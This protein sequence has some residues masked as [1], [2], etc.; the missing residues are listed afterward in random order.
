[1]C[2]SMKVEMARR[3]HYV[4]LV[5]ALSI[6]VALGL[7]F[8][9]ARPVLR[10][11]STTSSPLIRS[12]AA[13]TT[14]VAAAV[15]AVDDLDDVGDVEKERND[16]IQAIRSCSKMVAVSASLDLVLGKP[17]I[18]MNWKS[19]EVIL[20]ALTALWKFSFAFN[21]ASASQMYIAFNKESDAYKAALDLEKILTTMTFV[22]RQSGVMVAIITATKVAVA[23]KDTL[24]CIN[25]GIMA[26]AFV[27]FAATFCAAMNDTKSLDTR[28][29]PNPKQASIGKIGRVTGRAMLLCSTAFF[30]E[31]AFALLLAASSFRNSWTSSI[32]ALLN[33]PNP[34]AIAGLLRHL[35]R[36][37]ISA[38]QD[39]VEVG[40]DEF[41]TTP[42]V[43]KA[44]HQSQQRF[45]GKV[46]GVVQVSLLT[47][48]LVAVS[49]LPAVARFMSTLAGR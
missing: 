22:W 44:L 8:P 46:K 17:A 2:A 26:T 38:L 47:K 39:V 36:D 18:E 14:Y 10:S 9:S 32:V 34:L 1:M 43:R 30:L 13:S 6:N 19:Q 40:N 31:A 37:F 33:I 5:V 25:K 21:T 16:A 28:D 45:Y 11:P 41:H 15:S 20:L 35:R 49:K 27:T 7:S 24:P 4:L 12:K 23:W 48:V 3:Y 42:G 29:H